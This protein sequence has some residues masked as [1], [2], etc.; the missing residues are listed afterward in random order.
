MT[1]SKHIKS[2][3]GTRQIE[4]RDYLEGI[5]NFTPHSL[6]SAATDYLVD[7]KD[8]ADG[9]ASAM[10]SHVLPVDPAVLR[11]SQTTKTFY[12]FAQRIPSKIEAMTAWSEALVIEYKK[13]GG[14]MPI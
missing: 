3:R 12:D 7:R 9:A 8:I 1:Y 2:M 5:P 10:L 4:H 13:L 6:R 14:L 11:I